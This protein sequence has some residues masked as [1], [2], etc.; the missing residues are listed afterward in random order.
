MYLEKSVYI[1]QTD[2]DTNMYHLKNKTKRR[3]EF[4]MQKEQ[5][6]QSD[7]NFGQTLKYFA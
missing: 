3:H 1:Y 7:L 2:V 6:K 5:S 4:S